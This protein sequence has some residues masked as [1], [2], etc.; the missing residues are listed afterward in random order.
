MQRLLSFLSSFGSNE[1]KVSTQSTYE[2]IGYNF[3]DPHYQHLPAKMPVSQ[4]SFDFLFI[5][6]SAYDN[7]RN[8]FHDQ[9]TQEK[10]LASESYYVNHDHIDLNLAREMHKDA[11]KRIGVTNKPA[12]PAK[13]YQQLTTAF[14]TLMTEFARQG[15][16]LCQA[17]KVGHRDDIAILIGVI[18][19]SP[20]MKNNSEMNKFLSELKQF[21][22]APNP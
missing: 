2:I 21:N 12:L 10:S 6:L 14:D 7:N 15:I 18:E 9:V 11:M 20:Y 22:P 19:K 16:E 17:R 3:Y 5:L 13:T 8:R 4:L 1:S